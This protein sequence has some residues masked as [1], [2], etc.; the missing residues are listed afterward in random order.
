M[1]KPKIIDARDGANQENIQKAETLLNLPCSLTI[2]NSR[3]YIHRV[4]RDDIKYF[5]ANKRLV[6][7]S[8]AVVVKN[9][10]IFSITL[11][12]GV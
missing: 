4:N 6:G 10:A 12:E 8:F 3:T 11:K 7:G 1:A 5:M 2:Q 9:Y